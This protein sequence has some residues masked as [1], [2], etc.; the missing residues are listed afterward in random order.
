M[1]N[2]VI[3]AAGQGT[4]MKSNR[5]KTLQNVAGVAILRR[6][7]NATLPLK[8]EKIV[9]ICG[10]KANQ[11]IDFLKND[12]VICAIQKEQKGTADALLTAFPF[13][14]KNAPT[15]AL[16][17]D[18]PLISSDSLK[19]LA[20]TAGNSALS[21]L[22]AKVENPF[23]Y[24]RIVRDENGN[25]LK[26]VEEKDADCAQKQIKEINT[27]MMVIPP[28]LLP[29]VEKIG[30]HN[31]QK[32]QYLTDIVAIAI[33]QKIPVRAFL[34]ED[35]MEGEGVNDKI[36]LAKM[37]RLIQSR[38]VENLMKNGV[39][40]ADPNRFDLRGTLKHGS[41]VFIDIGVILEGN[42]VFSD[43]VEIGAYCVL[44]NVKIARNVRILP[45]THIE[46]ATIG[47]NA[48]VGPFA[49]LRPDTVLEN[50]VHVGNFVEI[51]KSILG[52]NTKAGH[53][54]YLGDAEIGQS[55]NIGAG[56]ITC[57]YDG[58]KKHKTTIQN[59]AFIGSDT[60]LVAPVEVGENALIAAGTTLTKN[61][62][63]HSLTHSRSQ[64]KSFKKNENPR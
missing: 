55:V 15:L 17:G 46:N 42:C 32:E 35:S 33:H 22:T 49:R 7:L 14:D 23:G 39:T 38:Q 61:A 63:P 8:P 2:I 29:F 9:V 19:R 21:L 48:S 54:S 58:K 50:D 41:D 60:Q 64:Q 3:F 44:K 1:M 52:K 25:V 24:G 30:T 59:G 18:V 27:G 20:Q 51:K 34:L 6:I 40:F 57:N 4:R 36:A 12:K 13:I 37:E 47:E 31:A 16:V 56:T 43:N 5:P 45:F 53:L 11:M 62:P 10:F 28:S 26:I